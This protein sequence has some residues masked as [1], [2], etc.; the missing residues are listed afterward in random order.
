MAIVKGVE[1][2]E[3]VMKSARIIGFNHPKT[4][5]NTLYR[6]VFSEEDLLKAVSDGLQ[7]GCNLF[8]IRIF[9]EKFEELRK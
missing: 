7:R 9:Y 5:H 8:S 1:G 3:K 6:E 2:A 4:Q